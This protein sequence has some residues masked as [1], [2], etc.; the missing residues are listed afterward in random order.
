MVGTAGMSQRTSATS[1]VQ[2]EMLS[3]TVQPLP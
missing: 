1:V 2:S 3:L